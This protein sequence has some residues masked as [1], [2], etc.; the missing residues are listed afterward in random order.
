MKT[1]IDFDQISLSLFRMRNLSDKSF[2]EN[3]NT[4]LYSVTFLENHVVK[5]IMWKVSWV[6][7]R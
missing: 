7:H 1:D 2:R 4:L 5:G 3:Q 6:V